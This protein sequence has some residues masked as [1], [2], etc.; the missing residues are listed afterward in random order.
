[1]KSPLVLRMEHDGLSSSEL[2]N[3]IE[4]DVIVLDNSENEGQERKTDASSETYSPEWLSSISASELMDFTFPNHT[5]LLVAN[6]RE[7][8]DEYSIRPTASSDK[9]VLAYKVLR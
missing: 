4:R 5:V 2:S 9:R 3:H 1:M 6:G 7:T 8:R